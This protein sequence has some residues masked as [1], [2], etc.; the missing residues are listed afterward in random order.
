M[1]NFETGTADVHSPDHTPADSG[2]VITP[3]SQ[4]EILPF[5]AQSLIRCHTEKAQE[6]IGYDPEEHRQ[7]V[8]QLNQFNA[9]KLSG[10]FD[11]PTPDMKL[12]YTL[13]NLDDSQASEHLNLKTLLPS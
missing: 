5:V 2:E 9:A 8:Q 6:K 12:I 7:D 4:E 3:L 11:N 10:T 13:Y 1:P